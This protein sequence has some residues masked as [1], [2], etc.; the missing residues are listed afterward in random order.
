M[1]IQITRHSEALN[2]AA[3]VHEA[4]RASYGATTDYQLHAAKKAWAAVKELERNLINDITKLE[5][6][7]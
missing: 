3:L 6:K 4:E 5:G 1:T 7:Q 2:I